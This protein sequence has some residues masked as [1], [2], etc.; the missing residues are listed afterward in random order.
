MSISRREFLKGSAAI[1]GASALPAAGIG[2]ESPNPTELRAGVFKQRIVSSGPETEVWGFNGTVPGPLLRY[3]Q[4]D[5]V[6]ISVRNGLHEQGTTVHWHGVRLPNPMDGVPN[7]T[8]EPIAPGATFPYEFPVTDSGTYWYHPHRKSFEQV[9]RGLF[10][11]LIVDERKPIEV[12]REVIW[13]LSDFKLAR[14]N[15]QVNDFG[16]MRDLANMGR[17]GNVMALN[18]KALV[19]DSTFE[20]RSGERLRLRLA[21]AATAR[22]LKLRIQG[23]H[24]V[25]IAYDGQAVEPHQVS[26]IA[27]G[28]GMRVDLVLD[29]MGRPG[30]RFTVTDAAQSNR[31][32][33]KIAYSAER[34]LR[35]KPLGA[36]LALEPNSIP[37]PDLAKASLHQILFQGGMAGQPTIGLV[38]GKTIGIQD[39]MQKHGLAWT[40]NFTAEQEDA[41][42]HIPFLR[43]KRGEHCLLSMVNETGF[44]HPMHLH[45]Y[46]F[47]VVGINGEA[48]K[49]PITR[50]TVLIGPRQN[51]DIA[52]VANNPGDWMFHCHILEHAAGGMMGTIRVG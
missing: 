10:G 33:L 51:I 45:G 23:H 1:I 20:V 43:L 3:K 52:F 29:C 37:E 32:L 35:A 47:R 50:D 6:R 18:G 40:M 7:V 28:P 9:A 39:I 5:N 31:E 21:N 44:E 25:A 49:F 12:D 24:P 4:G 48:P 13:V 26:E 14:D 15:Q 41:L 30:Q 16:N 22:I 36:P 42:N 27:L 17:L 11:V 34:P 2:A 19:Q 8:Q 38:D 46:Q